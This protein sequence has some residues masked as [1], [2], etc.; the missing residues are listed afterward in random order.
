[1][2]RCIR[3]GMIGLPLLGVGPLISVF[4]TKKVT[5]EPSRKCATRSSFEF[6]PTPNSALQRTVDT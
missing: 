5:V 3:G 4:K 2:R 1:L 6:Q